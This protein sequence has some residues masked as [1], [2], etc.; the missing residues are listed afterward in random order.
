MPYRSGYHSSHRHRGRARRHASGVI[1]RA[2]RNRARRRAGGLVARTAKANRTAIRKINKSIETKMLELPTGTP[3]NNYA[4]QNLVRIQVDVNGFDGTGVPVVLKPFSQLAQGD[5]AAQRDGDWLKVKSLTY[6]I[7]FQALSGLIAETNHVG[8]IIALDRTPNEDVLPSINGIV[9]GTP[10][11]GTLLGGNSQLVHLRYQNM[12]TCGKT[13]R[14][15][16]LRH[17]RCR[18]Q[19]QTAGA[20]FPPDNVKTGTL[21]YPYNL[22]YDTQDAPINQ[23]LCM[24]FYSDSAVTPHPSV[25]CHCRFRFKD[26]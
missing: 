25:S 26:A 3:A 13:L 17:I 6:K 20:V 1:G 14:Y 7:Y 23:Q 4:G 5:S 21:K 19:T 22:R 12:D 2:W 18:V 11:D 16:V 15:K 24:F 8:C 9:A 10:D